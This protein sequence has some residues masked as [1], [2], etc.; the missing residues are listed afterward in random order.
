MPARVLRVGGVDEPFNLPWIHAFEQNA[1]ADL[2]LEVTFNVV[3]GGTGELVRL[4]EDGTLDLATLLTEGAVTAIANGA[5][6]RLHSA[7]TSTPLTWGI[8]VAAD[9]DASSIA[10]LEGRRFAISRFGSGSELMARVLA[11]QQGWTLSDDQ[12]VVVGGLDGAIEALPAGDADIFLWERFV[13]APLVTSGVFS[14]VDDLPP[15]WPAFYT[16]ARPGVLTN[17]RATIDRVVSVVLEHAAALASDVDT[18]V[19]EIVERYGMSRRD[20][21]TWLGRVEWPSAP[22]VD[23]D[24]LASTMATMQVVGRVA[25]PVPT[26]ALL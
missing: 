15:A 12:F 23:H 16:A 10:D 22:T 6:L 21:R 20:T 2:G 25:A 17:D 4:L 7:F 9:D 5:G 26:A 1:F 14:R 19:D 24:V 13:T 8:H 3:A 18:T 11:D